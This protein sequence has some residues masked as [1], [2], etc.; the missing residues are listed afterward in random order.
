M[1]GGPARATLRTNYGAGIAASLVAEAV[2]IVM[3]ALVSW[4]RGMDPWTVAR[5]PASFL[6][7]PAAVE[8]PG[9]ALGDVLLGLGM[10][11]VLG[12]LVGSV[13]AALLPRLGI[14]P[15]AGGLITGATLYG[16]GFWMLPLLFP[17]WLAPFWLPPAGTVLQALAHAVYG[18]IFGLAYRRFA[19]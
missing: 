10:H 16:L 4:I 6:L 15:V 3:V 5:V 18:V 8:P 13:Y 17:V 2:F 14:S 1:T 19:R 11:L 7:G 12:I 9:F